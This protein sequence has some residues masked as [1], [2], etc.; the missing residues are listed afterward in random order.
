MVASDEGTAKLQRQL[1]VGLS[2]VSWRI[3]RY[4]SSRIV[5]DALLGKSEQHPERALR[6]NHDSVRVFRNAQSLGTQM[7][8]ARFTSLVLKVTE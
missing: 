1:A 2:A 6:L 3:A 4:I 7:L 8:T 5:R